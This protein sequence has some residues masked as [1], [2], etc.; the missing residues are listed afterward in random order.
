ML[1]KS[2]EVRKVHSNMSEEQEEDSCLLLE[3][4]NI[5]TTHH[6]H[7]ESKNDEACQGREYHEFF[8][9]VSK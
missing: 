2:I 5:P 9:A 7:G 3:A 4:L 1:Q 6:T 8:A